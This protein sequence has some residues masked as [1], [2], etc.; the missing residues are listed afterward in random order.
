MSN[1][2]VILI[3]PAALELIGGM[4]VLR[5]LFADEQPIPY[6]FLPGKPTH[7]NWDAYWQSHWDELFGVTQRDRF[8]RAITS[9]LN[10]VER[11]ALIP[12]SY[13]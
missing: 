7:P 3:Q 6:V 8:T 5:K 13:P 9:P 2:K 1:P 11:R 4:D 10:E 12:Q